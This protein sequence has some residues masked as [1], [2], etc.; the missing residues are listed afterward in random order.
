MDW[1]GM[2]LY[3]VSM[4]I[5]PGPNNLTMMYCS[6][7][8]GMSRSWRFALGSSVGFIAK[9]FLCGALNLALSRAIPAAMPYLKWIGGLYMLYLAYKMLRAGYAPEEEHAAKTD[10]CTI[11]SGLILQCFNMKSWVSCLGVFV[12]VVPY[13]TAFSAVALAACINSA[14]MVACTFAWGAFGLAFR[15]VYSAHRKAFSILLAASLALCAVAA[16]R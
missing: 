6:A 3:M 13:T 1:A 15:R 2:L 5:T 14:L 9:S 4:L 8:Y 16:V 10:D 12:F 7:R 11:L